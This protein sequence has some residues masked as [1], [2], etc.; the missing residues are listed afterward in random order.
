MR[1]NPQKHGKQKRRTRFDVAQAE[2]VQAAPIALPRIRPALIL[3]LFAMTALLG[4][5]VWYS[6]DAWRIGQIEI[7]GNEGV[8]A[9]QII[10]ASGLQGE[11]FHWADLQKAAVQIDA[12]PGVEASRVDCEWRVQTRCS[13]QVKPA[14]PLALIRSNAGNVWADYEGKV[15]RAPEQLSAALT[16][17]VT[18]GETPAPGVPMDPALLRALTELSVIKPGGRYEYSSAYGLIFVNERRS[19]VRLGTASRDGLMLEKI[20]LANGLAEQLNA[21]GIIPGVI[22]V[23]F[24]RAPYYER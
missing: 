8:P 18:D 13:I 6:G 23:R 20:R 4:G 14:Q 11:H 24:V 5:A 22:D 19:L 2:R 3:A 1:Y 16:V 17:Q 9:E 12:L 7:R 15:Q 21:R 10:G